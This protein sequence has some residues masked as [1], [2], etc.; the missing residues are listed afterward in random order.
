VRGALLLGLVLLTSGCAAK[1][2]GDLSPDPMFQTRVATSDGWQIALFRIPAATTTSATAHHGTP[3]L[4]AHGT[5]VNRGNFLIE[6]SSLAKH[7]ASQGFDVWLMEYRG[8]RSSIPPDEATWTRGAW[9]VDEMAQQDVPA[10]LDHIL[11]TTGQKQ[12]LFV[13]HSLGGVLGYLTLQGPHAN[14]VR[15]MVSIA[16][17]GDFSHPNDLAL[18]ALKHLGAVPKN[19]QLPSRSLAKVARPVLD[20]DPDHSLLH[21]IFNEPNVDEGVLLDWMPD[22]ME[23]VGWGVVQ[24]YA[25]WV[26]SGVLQSA[27]GTVNYTAGLKQIRAPMLFLAGRVDHI[28]P[29]WTV[30]R[31]HDLVS[32]SDKTYVTLG[33]G[34]GTRHEYGHAGPVAGDWAE[35]EV[36]GTVTDWLVAHAM[37]VTPTLAV[38]PV[39]PTPASGEAV[40]DPWGAATP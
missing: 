20:R 5:V 34:W 4:M 26:E 9:N 14:R 12:A 21:T 40:N 15:G 16:A 39:T 19:Q 28:V 25:S 33:V 37:T 8:D 22:A 29:P 35:E 31:A 3:V 23:N 18:K 24:Q 6:G 1:R 13:G 38:P 36:F 27:D 10:A 32:S 11:K 17:P 7:L 2:I 30:R